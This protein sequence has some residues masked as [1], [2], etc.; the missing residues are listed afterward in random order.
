MISEDTINKLK[1]IADS[2]DVE[3]EFSDIDKGAS[4]GSR[5]Y[6]E[7]GRFEDENQLVISFFHELAHARTSGLLLRDFSK[8]GEHVMPS[9]LASEGF[10]WTFAVELAKEHGFEFPIGHPIYAFV[11]RNLFSYTFAYNDDILRNSLEE[12]EINKEFQAYLNRRN[13]RPDGR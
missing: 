6:I 4:N 9:A 7:L 12:N 1:Q 8:E 5:Y 10:A 2:Y 3:L 11:Y 13:C